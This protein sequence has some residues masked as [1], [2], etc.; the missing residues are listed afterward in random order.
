MFPVR[1]LKRPAWFFDVSQQGE[2]IVD[3]TTHLVDLVQWECFPGQSLDYSKDIQVL[4]ARR[5]ATKFTPEQFN[6][7]TRLNGYPDYLKKFVK[8]SVLSDYC[9][10]EINYKIKG[11]YTKITSI[12]NY[13]SPEGSGDSYNSMMRGS[14]ASLII[15]QGPEQNYQPTLYIEPADGTDLSSFEKVLENG[16]KK[17]NVQYEWSNN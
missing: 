7:I 16:I 4:S 3:I 5:W 8:D 13:E 11:V 10:G 9:N 14:K 15:R 12:W 2:G 6:T 17:I 1:C